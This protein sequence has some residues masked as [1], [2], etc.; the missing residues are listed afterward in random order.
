MT[1]KREPNPGDIMYTVKEHR[2]RVKGE[3]GVRFEYVVAKAEVKEIRKA[4]GMRPEMLTIVQM[5]DMNM[6]DYPYLSKVGRT[7]FYTR[8][9]AIEFAEK[10]SDDFEQKWSKFGEKLRRSWR[11]DAGRSDQVWEGQ[12]KPLKKAAGRYAAY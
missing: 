7:Y 11:N 10:L 3:A 5:P 12:Q 2:Y 6:M 9:E 8:E 4:R 1:Q